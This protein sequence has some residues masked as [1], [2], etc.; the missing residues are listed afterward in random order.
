MLHVD[1]IV[2]LFPLSVQCPAK[3]PL[4]YVK[5]NVLFGETFL[6]ATITRV[7]TAILTIRETDA[8]LVKLDIQ[9]KRDLRFF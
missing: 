8:V 3:V 2:N 9:R 5:L 6:H 1:Q 7:A 4:N